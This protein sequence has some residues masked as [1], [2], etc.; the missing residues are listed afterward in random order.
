[1]SHTFAPTLAE[2]SKTMIKKRIFAG[3]TPEN[4]LY[5]LEIETERRLSNNKTADFTMSG[6]TVEPISEEAGRERAEEDLQEGETWKM[7]VQA[8]Q[9]HQGL[10][11]WVETVLN[12]DGWEHVLDCSLY[13][14]KIQVKGVEYGFV[15]G[16][17]GQ[18]EIEK[19]KYYAIAKDELDYLMK[20]WKKYH[21]KELTEAMNTTIENMLDTIKQDEDEEVKK[22]LIKLIDDGDNDCK[23]CDNGT[24]NCYEH[25]KIAD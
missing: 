21:L 9:T 25:G 10:D 6:F 7:A 23:I 4:E 18:H 8:D 2:R 15:S 12:T 22:A 11:D 17:C 19:L 16:S 5:F 20:V 13:P 24:K 14:E 1:V 3:I